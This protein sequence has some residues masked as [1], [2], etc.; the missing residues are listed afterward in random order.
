VNFA[1]F[2]AESRALWAFW[3]ARLSKLAPLFA[4]YLARIGRF[5]FSGGAVRFDCLFFD[6]LTGK[7]GSGASENKLSQPVY[8]PKVLTHLA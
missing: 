5:A 6:A 8:C 7:P 3:I 1:S 2:R 4:N